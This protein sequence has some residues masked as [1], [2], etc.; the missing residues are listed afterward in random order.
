MMLVLLE[1]Q[2]FYLPEKEKI[3]NTNIITYIYGGTNRMVK[4]SCTA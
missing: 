2:T 4:K 1:L 3:I